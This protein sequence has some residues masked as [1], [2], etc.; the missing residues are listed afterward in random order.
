MEHPHKRSPK[1]DHG[2]RRGQVIDLKSY[3]RRKERKNGKSRSTDLGSRDRSWLSLVCYVLM[4]ITLGFALLGLASD[5]YPSQ[6]LLSAM[7]SGTVG[8]VLGLIS[9]VLRTRNAARM[10]ILLAS[11]FALAY[12]CSLI[13]A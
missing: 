13:H 10:L 3:Q 6:F 7:F 11:A 4:V 2:S 9:Y 12:L 1:N 8:L 5:A